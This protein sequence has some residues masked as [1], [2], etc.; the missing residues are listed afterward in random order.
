MGCLVE[1]KGKGVDSF[2]LARKY[3]SILFQVNN[4]PVT[5]KELDLI[6]FSAIHGTISTPPIREEFSKRFG[7][8]KA[9]IYNMSSKLQKLNIFVKASDNKIRVNPK[10][11]LDFSKKAYKFIITLLK[12]GE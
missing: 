5:A 3:Y 1:I 12:E 7:I 8:P 11:Q 9:S 10:I 4:I 6:A 2:D